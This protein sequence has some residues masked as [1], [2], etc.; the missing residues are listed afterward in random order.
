MLLAGLGVFRV[1]TVQGQPAGGTRGAHATSVAVVDVGRVLEALDE[2][3]VEVARLGQFGQQLADEVQ[4][5]QDQRDAANADLDVLPKGTPQWE[6]KQNEAIRLEMKLQSEK[7]FAKFRLNKEK[8]RTKLEL[9]NK[10]VEAAGTYAERE[11][12]DIVL[13]D[14]RDMSIPPEQLGQLTDAQFE[15]FVQSRRLIFATD[16]SDITDEVAQMMN[17]QFKARTPDPEVK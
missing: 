5:I 9:F 10:I 7:E 15:S 16:A 3:A 13:N 12:Y 6:D 11:G 17:T 8:Q 1:G 4:K 14:D 2:K